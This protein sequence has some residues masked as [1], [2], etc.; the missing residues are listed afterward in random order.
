MNKIVVPYGKD[1]M[2]AKVE[3]EDINIEIIDLPQA[4]SENEDE[5][6]VKAFNELDLERI[7]QASSI[8]VVVSDISRPIPNEKILSY[9]WPYLEKRGVKKQQ[10]SFFIASGMH[11]P[12]NLKEVKQILGEYFSQ[13]FKVVIHDVDSSPFKQ[14]GVTSRG[15]PVDLNAEFLKAEVKIAIGSVQP[16]QIAGYSGG[17]KS[18][19]I[20]LGSKEFITA[21]HGLLDHPSCQMGNL[22]SL[23]RQEMEEVAQMAN[24]DFVINLVL[25]AKGRIAFINAGSISESYLN[26]V[27]F[28]SS[29]FSIPVK[30]SKDIVV[31]SPGGYPKD[32]NLYQAQKA[33]NSGAKILKPG[34]FLIL[35]ASCSQGI[36]NEDF[37]KYMKRFTNAEE[38]ITWFS[39][40]PFQIGPHKAYIWAKKVKENKI[41]L[42]SDLPEDEVKYLMVESVKDLSSAL[43]AAM[44]RYSGNLEIG[45]IPH[46]SAVMPILN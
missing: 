10:L 40:E 22:N 13:E 1:F 37:L 14:I 20:G 46:G 2:E 21:N 32:L 38:L 25:D 41:I 19:A 33:L 28:A 26:A 17:A 42:V 3:K 39:R 44:G 9:F 27:K 5:L 23:A 11:K 18:V 31:V 30:N 7:A 36:G 4:I 12:A 24:L 29:F 16:H 43:R 8:A 6:I 35:V 15:T 45:V 34:G